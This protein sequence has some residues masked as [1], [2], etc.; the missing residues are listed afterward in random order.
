MLKSHG[1]TLIFTPLMMRFPTRSAICS[2]SQSIP[3]SD[4][5]AIRLN[6]FSYWSGTA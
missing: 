3:L 6:F 1:S 5:A 4:V 2:A